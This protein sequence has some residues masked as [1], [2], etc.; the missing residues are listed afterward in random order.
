[1]SP[2]KSPAVPQPGADSGIRRAFAVLAEFEEFCDA[3]VD[4]LSQP[5]GAA[6]VNAFIRRLAR[7]RP[8]DRVLG[9]KAQVLREFG[10]AL[11]SRTKQLRY[12]G[13]RLVELLLRQELE[14]ARFH[15][16]QLARA[17]GAPPPPGR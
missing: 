16:A 12:G 10:Q 7:T 1:M 8:S 9:M 17:R 2:S 11:V 4:R 14:S 6:K 3:A 15:L 13:R 5:A